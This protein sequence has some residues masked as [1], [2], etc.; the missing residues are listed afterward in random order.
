MQEKQFTVPG[1]VGSDLRLPFNFLGEYLQETHDGN[2]KKFEELDSLA[3]KTQEQLSKLQ[4]FSDFQLNQFVPNQLKETRKIIKKKAQLAHDELEKA[5][6]EMERQLTEE[7]LPIEHQFI[8]T[9]DHN[10]KKLISK[11]LPQIVLLENQKILAHIG[12]VM[13][14]IEK[15]GN[16]MVGLQSQI[17]EKGDQVDKTQELLHQKI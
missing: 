6:K 5:I 2:K 9:V 10:L 12:V 7:W 8:E 3:K 13:E 11:D 1:L 16:E 14:H 4:E 15:L 17:N